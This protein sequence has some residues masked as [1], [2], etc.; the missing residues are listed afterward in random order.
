MLEFSYCFGEENDMSLDS[1]RDYATH[2]KSRIVVGN[3][4]S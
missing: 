4:T 3:I 2:F 1:K